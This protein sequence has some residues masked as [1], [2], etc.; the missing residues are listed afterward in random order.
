[1]NEAYDVRIVIDDPAITN[2]PLTT[3]FNEESLDKI[4]SIVS[5]TLNIKVKKQANKIILQ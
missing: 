2:L 3:T 4:L 1:L 5:A